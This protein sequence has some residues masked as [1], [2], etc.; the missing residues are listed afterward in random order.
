MDNMEQ[1]TDRTSEMEQG[2]K[3]AV[4]EARI[5]YKGVLK[6]EWN[7][8]DDRF[9]LFQDTDNM[10]FYHG[11]IPVL[12]IKKAE[13]RPF[14]AWLKTLSDKGYKKHGQNIKA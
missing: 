7:K 4:N 9:A 1:G 6:A 5:A 13:A 2:I 10:Y 11:A 8:A 3:Q 14:L 12:E